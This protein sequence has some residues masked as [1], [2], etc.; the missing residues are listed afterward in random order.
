MA[1]VRVD[2]FAEDRGHE[3]F[4]RHLIPRIAAEAALDASVRKISARGGHGRAVSEFK[5]YQR[6]LE[7]VGADI[8]DLIVV[9][10]DAN[11]L[12][13]NDF[14]TKL[15][16]EIAE[17]WTQRVIPACPDPHIE[18]WFLADP[19]SFRE[20]VG[21]EP[22]RERRKCERDRY[23]RLLREAVRKGGHLPTLGGVEFAREIVEAM[24]LYRAGRSEPSLR[25]FVEGFQALVRRIAGS[26][27]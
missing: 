17:R 1:S 3:E 8:P 13:W 23:K 27:A 26:Q 11:C 5:T 6:V 18:R 19:P 15:Q 21:A 16:A 2:L 7:K 25:A 9:A 4:L 10:I 12:G 20:V 24:D 22:Q 14:R